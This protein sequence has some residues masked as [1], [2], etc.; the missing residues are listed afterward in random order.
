MIYLTYFLGAPLNRDSLGERA[1]DTTE[2]KAAARVRAR[3]A[4]RRRT[5]DKEEQVVGAG[6]FVEPHNSA[7]T[8]E[9][10]AKSSTNYID[11]DDG[12]SVEPKQQ[13]PAARV[14]FD[15][16]IVNNTTW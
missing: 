2:R 16:G 1:S 5:N 9:R 3:K 11:M 8:Q 13:Q 15:N 10:S 7:D 4:G 12:R 6:G 14:Y